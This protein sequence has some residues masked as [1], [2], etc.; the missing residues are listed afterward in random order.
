MRVIDA[1]FT[2]ARRIECSPYGPRQILDETRRLPHGGRKQ[3]TTLTELSWHRRLQRIGKKCS[4]NEQVDM[5]A[6]EIM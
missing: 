4:G 5:G 3:G 2:E 6:I 1:A